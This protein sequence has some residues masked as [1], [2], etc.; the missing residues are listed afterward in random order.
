VRAAVLAIVVGCYNPTF[1]AGSPCDESMPCP[2]GLFCTAGACQT[3]SS[4]LDAAF[5]DAPP[6]LI[7]G[8]SPV[9]EICGDG[10]DQDCDGTDPACPPNDKAAGAIDIG[11]GGTFTGDL[12]YATDDAQKPGG[13]AT[14]CGSDGGRDL[15]YKIHLQFDQAIYLDTF[16]S[17]FDSVIRVVHGACADGAA[18]VVGTVCHNDACGGKQTQFIWDMRAGDNCVIVDQNAPEPNGSL[19]MHVELGRRTGQP[20]TLGTPISSDTTS[21]GDQMIGTCS[22]TGNDVGFHF[23]VCPNQ[24]QTIAATT[25]NANLAFDSSMYAKG[26]SGQNPLTNLACN[27]DDANCTANT[28]ASTIQFTAAGPHLYWIIVDAG[29]PDAAGVFELDTTIQ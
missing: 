7:D 25:C 21:S 11:A 18:P 19:V 6:I 16:G 28:S 10:I 24:T 3:E 13:A 27:D 1:H 20:L 5:D 15:Y 12:R 2:S 17:N 9:A 23:T 26:A 8:C 4:P 14:L 22:Q 29:A